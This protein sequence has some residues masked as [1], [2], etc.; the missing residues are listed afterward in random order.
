MQ[1][2][3]IDDRAAAEL[4]SANFIRRCASTGM[5]P[6]PDDQKMFRPCFGGCV[7]QMI[8]IEGKRA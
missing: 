6:R 2:V 4:Y 3:Q 7:C 5:V 8:A 1:I